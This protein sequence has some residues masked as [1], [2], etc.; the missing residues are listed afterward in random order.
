MAKGIAGYY[1]FGNCLGLVIDYTA[2]HAYNAYWW[3]SDTGD[4]VLKKIE[5]QFPLLPEPF[6]DEHS[7]TIYW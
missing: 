3:L 4:I 2:R 5:P 7:G 6:P 1:G